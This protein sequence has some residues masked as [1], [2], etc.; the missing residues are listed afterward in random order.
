MVRIVLF[1]TEYVG[2]VCQSAMEGALSIRPG[3]NLALYQNPH[4][5]QRRQQRHT[6]SYQVLPPW[7]LSAEPSNCVQDEGKDYAE[8]DRCGERK[9]ERRVLAPIDD[10]TGKAPQRQVTAAEQKNDESS[11]DEHGAKDDQEFADVG[12]DAVSSAARRRLFRF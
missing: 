1:P 5:S 10:V 2:M 12:H 9:I 6:R 7:A 3:L 4:F 8:Q 11:D